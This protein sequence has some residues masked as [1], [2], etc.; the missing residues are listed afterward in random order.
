MTISPATTSRCSACVAVAVFLLNVR[1]T[2]FGRA[3]AA[4]REK[5]YAAAV[6]GVNTFYFKLMA[7]WVSSLLGGMAGALLAFCY[8]PRGD[9]RAIP[10][11]RFNPGPGHGDCRRTCERHR[12]LFL[13]RALVL[14]APIVFNNL[15]AARSPMARLQV[16][17]GAVAHKFR[18]ILYGG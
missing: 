9:A 18:L 14:F 16:E 2:A 5:D 12:K 13:A 6:L 8:L 1:R 3:L 7:F 4:V 17:R 10:P 11:R 15:V